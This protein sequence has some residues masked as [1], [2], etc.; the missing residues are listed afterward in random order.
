MKRPSLMRSP[1]SLSLLFAL[2]SMSLSGC[3]IPQDDGDDFEPPPPPAAAQFIHQN[4]QQ[5]PIEI[6]F[7]DGFITQVDLGSV[8]AAISLPQ[9]EGSF[10][11]YSLGAANPFFETELYT[12]EARA[13]TFAFVDDEV[14]EN[15]FVDLSD[16]TPEPEEDQHWLRFL[17]LSDVDAGKM[18]R[19]IEEMVSLPFDENPSEYIAVEAASETTLSLSAENGAPISISDSISLP[20]GGSS[21]LILG[22]STEDSSVTISAV[23]L[24]IERLN[25]VEPGAETM[26]EE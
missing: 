1:L 6:R 2:L 26:M 11:F 4:P 22:G 21:L 25:L 12:L 17:N 13:H 18:Y 10:A 8:S 15:N 5:G 14:A 23:A 9:G 19:G 20:S 7:N 16:A 3:F 24:D